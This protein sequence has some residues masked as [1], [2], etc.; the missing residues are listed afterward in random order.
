MPGRT[1]NTAAAL[2]RGVVG[3]HYITRIGRIAPILSR[4]AGYSSMRSAG[5]GTAGPSQS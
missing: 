3:C 5:A 1:S 2:A 4:S